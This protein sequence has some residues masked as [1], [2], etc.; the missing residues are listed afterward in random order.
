MLS[1][2]VS[3]LSPCLLLVTI[4]FK[5]SGRSYFKASKIAMREG[6]GGEVMGRF[7][8][9]DVWMINTDDISINCTAGFS[10]P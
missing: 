6:G 4:T 8:L 9:S 7:V 10:L 5:L 2:A 1:V 3:S